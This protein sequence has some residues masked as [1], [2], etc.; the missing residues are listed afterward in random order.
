MGPVGVRYHRAMTDSERLSLLRDLRDGRVSRNRA[1]ARFQE[2]EAGRVLRGFRRL[3]QLGREL[4]RPD[5]RAGAEPWN[6]GVRVTV[7]LAGVRYR[8]TVL[9]EP[10]EVAFLRDL[11][12][13]P[14]KIPL[15]PP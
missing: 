7:E 13:C 6:G 2:L 11:P 3:R 14:R 12:G 9:L 4:A 1:Y 15:D 5:A 8:R 10:W